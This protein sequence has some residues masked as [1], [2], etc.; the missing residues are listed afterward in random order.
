MTTDWVKLHQ[1]VSSGETYY[2]L[3]GKSWT[4]LGQANV[5][6]RVRLKTGVEISLRMPD[7]LTG[8]L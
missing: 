1:W 2:A 6:E 4:P 8:S 7:S 3:P 5:G